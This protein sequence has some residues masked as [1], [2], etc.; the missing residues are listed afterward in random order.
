MLAER[1]ERLEAAGQPPPYTAR[2]FVAPPQRFSE[3]A[4]CLLVLRETRR[5]AA[6]PPE[7]GLVVLMKVEHIPNSA[8]S[9]AA[10]FHTVY[11]KM[12]NAVALTGDG[13]PVDLAL[14]FAGSAARG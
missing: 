13:E 9:E 11:V 2:A 5:E 6:E 1:A 8:K 10:I 7:L 3:D 14:A 12:N 4:T